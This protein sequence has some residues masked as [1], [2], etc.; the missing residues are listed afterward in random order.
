VVSA[1][2]LI[3]FLRASWQRTTAEQAHTAPALRTEVFQLSG[4][5]QTF[6]IK[7]GQ[8]STNGRKKKL[9]LALGDGHEMFFATRQRRA[10]ALNLE[11]A[12]PAP[13][14]AVTYSCLSIRIPTYF[15][16][17][18]SALSLPTSNNL[19]FLLSL[20]VRYRLS[21]AL[22]K[23]DCIRMPRHPRARQS[24]RSIKDQAT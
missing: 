2:I 17:Y 20:E 16:V 18:A 5:F 15:C 22:E 6:R 7:T 12:R 4:V 8:S 1:T 23:Y 14:W 13:N 19:M 10:P 11:I 9:R 24:A 21:L 3:C